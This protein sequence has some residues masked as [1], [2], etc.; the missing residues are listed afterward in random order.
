MTDDRL[1]PEAIFWRTLAIGPA[2]L[3]VWLGL[4]V[5]WAPEADTSMTMLAMF[6]A[7][8]AAPVFFDGVAGFLLGLLLTRARVIGGQAAVDELRERWRAS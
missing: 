8:G 6:A 7:V 4:C 5:G 2:G 1:S 3:W